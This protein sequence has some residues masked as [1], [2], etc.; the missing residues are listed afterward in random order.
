MDTNK[1]LF[2]WTHFSEL[3][4][5]ATA[6]QQKI[7]LPLKVSLKVCFHET[8]QSCKMVILQNC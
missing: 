1:E 6:P 4:L 2:C 8:G 3:E 7:L 5:C